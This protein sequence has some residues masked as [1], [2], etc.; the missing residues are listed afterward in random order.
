M[1][2]SANGTPALALAA[3]GVVYGDIGTSPLYTI[4]E[5]FGS[6]HHPIVVNPANVLGILSLIFWSL[7][8]VIALKYVL[9]VMRADNKGEGGIMALMALVLHALRH[10]RKSSFLLLLG[11]FGAALFY[12]DSVITPAVSVLSAVEG[13]EIASPGL[14]RWIVPI[15]LVILVLL[16]MVQKHGTAEVGRF[17]GPVMIIWFLALATLGLVQIVHQPRV[18]AA[19]N[20]GYALHFFIANPKLGFLSLGAAVLA[21]TG[22]EALY[23]DMGHFGRKPVRLAWFGLVLP[24][25][26][27]NYFGQGA[28]L[29]EKG[30]SAVTNPFYLMAPGWALYPLVLLATLAT[31]I[32][33]QAVITGAFSMTQQA[34]QL[35]YVPR[36]DIQHTSESAIGQIYLPGINWALLIAVAALVV[37]FESSSRLAAAYGI[38]VTGTMVITTILATI[39]ARHVW[40]WPLALCLLVGGLFLLVDLA[41]FSANFVKI[42][43]GGWFPLVLGLAVF[44][45]MTTWKTGRE[46]INARMAKDAIPLDAFAQNMQD[47]GVTL[48]PGTAVFLSSDLSTTPHALLHSL[49][50]YK[51]L[52]ERIVV[53]MADTLEIPHVAAENR[54]AIEQLNS[55]FYCV[56]ASFGFMDEPD[57][58]GALRGCAKQGLDLD[59][60]MMDTSFFLGRETLVPK[61]GV[62]MR[63]W[64]RKLFVAMFRNSSS[65]ASYFQLPPNRVVELGSQMAF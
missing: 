8:I 6:I 63:S 52:H 31:V 46:E 39:V 54:L 2:E 47:C 17:F 10:S 53:L 32:A 18:L 36:M 25:L 64:Q 56:R 40:R 4:K 50:H 12:G 35:G 33:S 11:L 49:K 21:L 60:D 27:L 43:D 51:A 24:S 44:A 42:A 26:L 9:F 14:E 16:F 41:Y 62:Q 34:I 65:A 15:A 7:V 57:L 37:G 20:P 48:V 55:Q 19:V 58:I 29:L 59:L 30:A 3:L 38:A 28:L 1:K 13:L 23:A 61:V 5:V 22:G 45:A